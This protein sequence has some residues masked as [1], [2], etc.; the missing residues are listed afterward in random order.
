MGS[1]STAERQQG[2]VLLGLVLAAL[3]T[4]TVRGAVYLRAFLTKKYPTSRHPPSNSQNNRSNRSARLAAQMKNPGY[5]RKKSYCESFRKGPH[6]AIENSNT[7][8]GK[9][10]P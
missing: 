2:A 9:D 10:G 1:I 3:Q 7:E 5:P 6:E 4:E 8:R